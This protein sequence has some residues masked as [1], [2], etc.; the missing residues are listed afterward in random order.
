[1][2]WLS[3]QIISLQRM[4]EAISRCCMMAIARRIM[5]MSREKIHRTSGRCT[6]TAT[7]APSRLRM[8]RWTCEI[9]A[10]AKGCSS[11]STKWSSSGPPISVSITSRTCANGK[12]VA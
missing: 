12:P 4:N 8:A 6:L 2:I 5:N 9:D 10:A 11:N 1:M 3:S 7:S